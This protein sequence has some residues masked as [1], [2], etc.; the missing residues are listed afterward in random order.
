MYKTSGMYVCLKFEI[1]KGLY[2][3]LHLFVCNWGG[4]SNWTL[5]GSGQKS[6]GNPLRLLFLTPSPSLSSHQHRALSCLYLPVT[7]TVQTRVWLRGL[8]YLSWIGRVD[9]TLTCIHLTN[10][11][12]EEKFSWLPSKTQRGWWQFSFSG[13][14][15]ISGQITMFTFI[16]TSHQLFSF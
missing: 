14:H 15:K 9:H 6:Y 11:F 12:G 5:V 8:C 2:R 1:V 3:F 16:T 10:I 13:A 4:K 7:Y